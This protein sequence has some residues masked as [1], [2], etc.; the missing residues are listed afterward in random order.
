MLILDNV[1]RRF[2]A[3][4]ADVT[5]LR[6]VSLEVPSGGVWAVVGPNGAGKTTLFGLALGFLRP[7]AGRISLGGEDPRRYVRRNGAAYLPERFSLPVGWPV[8][9][10]LRAFARLDGR[11][12]LAARSR[13]DTMIERLGLQPQA[14]RP[15]G[16][17][18]R[19]LLQRMGLAQALLTER[20]MVVLDEPTEGLDPL[21]RI[22]LRDLVAELRSPERLVLI[23]SHALAEVERVADH[24]VLLEAGRVKDVL[25]VRG[26][27][28]GP[29]RYRIRLARP[30]SA[31]AEVFP[32]A[33][34]L[35]G[36]TDYVVVV[37]DAAELS[38]RLAALLARD[39]TLVEATP[40][41]EPLEDRVR[42]ALNDGSENDAGSAGNDARRSD[43]VHDETPEGPLPEGDGA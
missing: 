29:T 37:V 13:A 40:A 7:S 22:R 43:P 20:P 32:D 14:E 42:R 11:D 35:D 15:V 41:V 8:R 6:D 28:G 16:T 26:P 39:A 1:T 17:L 27:T 34:P 38:Q 36:D 4:G 31:M 33:T 25:D 5:A 3:P 19:G 24:V 21:W 2:R 18:S 10:A 23:A 12:R 30:S 9:A